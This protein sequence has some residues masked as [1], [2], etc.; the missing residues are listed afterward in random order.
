MNQYKE[1]ITRL[2]DIYN[3]DAI[4]AD[5]PLHYEP[6][7]EY[8]GTCEL[9]YEAHASACAETI[10]EAYRNGDYAHMWEALNEALKPRDDD[11]DELTCAILTETI[12]KLQWNTQPITPD[13]FDNDAFTRMVLDSLAPLT[14][15]Y[16]AMTLELVIENLGEGDDTEYANSLTIMEHAA[17]IILAR[18]PPIGERDTKRVT[19]DLPF[20]HHQSVADYIMRKPDAQETALTKLGDA[21]LRCEAAACATVEDAGIFFVNADTNSV[22]EAAQRWRDAIARAEE[23]GDS[24]AETSARRAHAH[25][26]LILMHR[27]SLPHKELATLIDTTQTPTA[28]AKAFTI[29]ISPEVWRIQIDTV[30]QLIDYAAT[31]MSAAL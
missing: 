9:D 11:C 28:G 26:C 4:G 1:R 21:I 30:E 14:A 25:V 15:E 19:R 10:A 24:E 13:A 27:R 5:I 29:V 8:Y 6:G 23:H 18:T 22:C 31:R 17:S 3:G 7:A 12:S 20:L 16:A 2:R